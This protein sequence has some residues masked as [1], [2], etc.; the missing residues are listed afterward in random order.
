VVPKTLFDYLAKKGEK[1][2]LVDV[3]PVGESDYREVESFAGGLKA[4]YLREPV[5]SFGKE[6]RSTLFP[7][8]FRYVESFYSSSMRIEAG[9]KLFYSKKHSNIAET[10]AEYVSLVFS[11]R[12]MDLEAKLNF[13]IDI[14]RHPLNVSSD[15]DVVKKMADSMAEMPRGEP[16]IAGAAVMELTDLDFYRVKALSIVHSVPT[17]LLNLKRFSD[18][19]EKCLK[20]ISRQGIKVGS[21]GGSALYI[22][23][24]C[25]GLSS[26]LL[27]NVVQLYAKAGGVP[28]GVGEADSK[29]LESTLVVGL[30]AARY[31]EGYYVGTAFAVAYMGKDVQSFVSADMFSRSELDLEV[32]RNRGLY[33]PS[34]VVEELF[35]RILQATRDWRIRRYVV[36][37]TP[38]VHEDESRG[39]SNALGDKFWILVHTKL[40]GFTKRV[41]DS[42][43]DDYGP[44]RGIC[45]V[46]ED[47][48]ETLRYGREGKALLTVTGKVKVRRGG[49]EEVENLYLATPRPLELEVYFNY[50]AVQRDGI[51]LY[52]LMVYASRLILLLNKLDWEAYSNWPK[53]PFVVKYAR[54]VAQM[55]ST[56]RESPNEEDREL[57]ETAFNTLV[58]PSKP[59]RLIM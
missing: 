28:W 59:L 40:S 43:T 7:R 36:F 22:V 39:L 34:R 10:F 23:A 17:H 29:L 11:R 45:I 47:S 6:L 19:H 42:S 32:L 13:D 9:L 24:S 14:E 49:K 25:S 54:R 21:P 53:M 55:L 38:V 48:L 37:Q 41:Y 18:I 4:L 50:S 20:K 5:L 15:A 8:E 35:K 27:N 46:D 2:E 31:G 33:I 58:R 44:Y 12:G 30:S 56:L 1:E 52:R 16:G 26:Y 3:V 57:A 51:D